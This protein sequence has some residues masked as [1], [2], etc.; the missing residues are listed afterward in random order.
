VRRGVLRVPLLLGLLGSVVVT[1]AHAALP[2]SGFIVVL[3]AGGD[4]Q[5]TAERLTASASGHLG[6]VYA[7]ALHG[8]S[9]TT[10]DAAAAALARQP[11][12]AYVERDLPVYADAQATPTAVSRTFSDTNPNL[13]INGV[14]DVRV[15][16]DVAVIDTGVDLQ[17]PDLNIAGGVNCLA[18]GPVSGCQAGGDDDNFHGT[19]VGGSIAALDNG[20]GVVGIAPG[21]RIWAV[22]VL[23]FTGS[24]T[25]SSVIRGIDWVTANAATIEVANMS[26][27]SPGFSQALHDSIQ[28]AVNAGV[29]FAVAAGNSH[30]NAAGFSPASF[31]NVLTVSALA[32]F[33][34]LSGAAGTS[35]CTP[36]QDDTLWDLSNFG[37]VD[38][39]A[40][41]VCITSTIPLELGSYGV[42]TGTS[43]ATSFVT[44]ALALLA[45][46]HNP[47]T[48]ADVQALYNQVLAAGNFNWTDDSGDGVKE[49]LL[50]VSNPN[51]FS[52][53]TVRTCAVDLTGLVGWWKGQNSLSAD[54]GLALSGSANF[55]NAVSGNGFLMDATQTLSVAG[56]PA[57]SSGATVE[58]W[59]KPAATGRIQALASR[60][61]FPS[62]DDGA[63]TFALWI[64]PNGDL[65]WTTDEASTRRPEELRAATPQL[66]DGGFHHVAA[67]WSA[68]QFA[69][70]LDGSLIA[71]K[72]SQ[73]GTLNPSTSTALRIGS[74]GG[75]GDDFR[76]S[77]IIDEPSVWKR[78][79]SSAE[80]SAI[81]T[82][83][84]AG[85]CSP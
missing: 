20:I 9:I 71:T 49:P 80:V 17:H 34:G 44:G 58:M 25:L 4:E 27:G 84:A 83:A 50:D 64:E 63:R 76:F 52:A 47:N 41:G 26:L 31:D 75:V 51:L 79:L 59:V 37:G 38:V 42:L 72:A 85:K 2:P 46:A 3:R 28:S 12:V 68:T 53:T 66:L 21:A 60:W 6:S 19:H 56:I 54:A 33:D 48:A 24:G 82:S 29:A 62:P 73:G 1:S 5:A 15:D 45:R 43:M 18:P 8:F 65:V 22:K 74:K 69:L 10:S 40:P 32:D 14:D 77:G 70:Y 11:Q 57:V 39:A 23:D 81:Y 36:D 30:Q 16:V 35:T 61:D 7:H 13:R 78:A 55:A 67:T